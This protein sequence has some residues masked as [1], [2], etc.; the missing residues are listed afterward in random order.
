MDLADKVYSEVCNF[1]NLGGGVYRTS[2]S[3]R[4]RTIIM[5]IDAGNAD[6]FCECDNSQVKLNTCKEQDTDL[7]YDSQLTE[8]YSSQHQIGRLIMLLTETISTNQT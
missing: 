7:D 4:I 8:L 6:D 3:T 5:I 2:H 1:N